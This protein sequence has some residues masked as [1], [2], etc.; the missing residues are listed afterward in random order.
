MANAVRNA[1]VAKRR[2][3]QE[4]REQVGFGSSPDLDNKRRWQTAISRTTENTRM[5]SP[6]SVCRYPRRP[7]CLVCCGLWPVVENLTDG[8]VDADISRYALM[9]APGVPARWLRVTEQF[10]RFGKRV[11][12]STEN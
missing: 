8:T 7:G 9:I 11:E 2:D 12:R 4:I 1:T 5:Q 6:S 3:L 10:I